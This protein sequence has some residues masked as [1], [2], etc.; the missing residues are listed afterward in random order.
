MKHAR[1]LASL[2]LALVMVFALAV[3]AFASET[4]T[5]PTTGTITVANPVANQEY[6]AYYEHDNYILYFGRYAREKGVLTILKAYAKMHCD[7]KLVLVGKG[8][9][10]ER[11][12]NFVKEHNLEGRVQVNGAIFG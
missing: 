3:T 7:E 8:S 2:L 6:K 12:K 11:I 9:E 10:E 4:V 1:K 5:P